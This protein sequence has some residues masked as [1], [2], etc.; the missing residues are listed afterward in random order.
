MVGY[1]LTST[2]PVPS[3]TSSTTRPGSPSIFSASPIPSLTVRDLLRWVC[4]ITATMSMSLTSLVDGSARLEDPPLPTNPGRPGKLRLPT[5]PQLVESVAPARY[6]HL[7]ELRKCGSES[8]IPT[9]SP[10]AFPTSTLS[11]PGDRSAGSG[12]C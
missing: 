3:S 9:C 8:T 7:G 5:H 6:Q 11:F 2:S 1:T 12:W 10:S 4:G